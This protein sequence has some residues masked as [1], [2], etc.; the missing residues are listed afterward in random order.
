M[1]QEL[2]DSKTDLVIIP[3]ELTPILKL[4]NILV[5]KL[6]KENIRRIYG[7]WMANGKKEKNSQW[8]NKHPSLELM[9]SWILQSWTF[10]TSDIISK[11]FK[12]TGT[13]NA[14]N[15]SEDDN[16]WND[17]DSSDTD[18]YYNSNT[19]TFSESNL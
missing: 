13:S 8:K 14:L 10:I 17:G 12:K 16:L 4:L 15:G 6:F 7:D 11:S 3:G 9:C 1:K 5:N 19:E 2:S 18:S